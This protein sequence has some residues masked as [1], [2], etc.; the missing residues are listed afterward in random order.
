[1]IGPVSAVIQSGKDDSKVFVTIPD[2]RR[3]SAHQTTQKDRRRR[4]NVRSETRV[5]GARGEGIG[6][7]DTIRGSIG[8]FSHDQ[9]RIAGRE[10]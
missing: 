5:L 10:R 1:M 8:S 3:E 7:P 6:Q 9:Q 2:P 4:A